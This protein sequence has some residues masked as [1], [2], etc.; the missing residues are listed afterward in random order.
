MENTSLSGDVW[1]NVTTS[2]PNTHYLAQIRDL[3]L[4]IVYI[5]IGTVGVLDNLFVILVFALFI[6]ITDKV[7]AILYSYTRQQLFFSTSVMP[8]RT[9]FNFHI[10]ICALYHK[11]VY[12]TVRKRQWAKEAKIATTLSFDAPS[13]ANPREYPHKLIVLETRFHGLHFDA[14]RMGLPSF[15]F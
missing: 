2:S 8:L 4:K 12:V 11:C 9:T 14:N 3:A 10:V 6:K 15:K 7:S 13:S 5:I 1:N